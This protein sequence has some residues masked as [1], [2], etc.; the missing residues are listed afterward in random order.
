MARCS[1]EVVLKILE[2][3]KKKLDNTSVF[4]GFNRFMKRWLV[5][6]GNHAGEWLEKLERYEYLSP[7]ERKHLLAAIESS[8]RV[9]SQG[10]CALPPCTKAAPLL[11]QPVRYLKGVGPSIE[12]K[13]HRLDIVT[14]EDLLFFFPRAYRD[15]GEIKPIVKLEGRGIETV[16]GKVTQHRIERT[17]RGPLLKIGVSDGT[18]EVYLVCFNRGY[19]AQVLRKGIW[20]CVSGS[21]Q[22][23]FG[24][25]E[26]ATF[27]YEIGKPDPQVFERIVPVYSLTEGLTP[28]TLRRIILQA[29]DACLQ[30]VPEVLPVTLRRRLGLLSKREAIRELHVPVRSTLDELETRRS[31]AHRTLILEEF[32]LFALSLKIRKRTLE[33]LRVPPCPFKSPLVERFI[34]SLPFPLTEAQKRVCSEIAQDLASGRVMNRLVQGDVGS[35]KTL[36]AIISALRVVDAGRQ[37]AF[38]VPTEILAEQHYSR[39]REPLFAL[40]IRVGL[41]K[42]GNTKEKRLLLEA[43]RRKEVDIVIGT[44]ALIE[45]KVVFAD[46]G[47]VIVDEQHRFGVLQRAKLKEKATVPH[48]LVMTATPIP[49]TLAL[50]LYGDLDVSIV[51]EKPAGRKPTKTLCFPLEERFKAYSRVRKL[52]KEGRQAYVV[53]PAIEET[54][55]EIATVQEVFEELKR[56]WLSEFRIEIIHGKLPSKEKEEVMRRFS[57]G[58]IDVLVATS[59]IEVG[60]D[61]P[62]AS[63]MVVE[64]AERFGLAQLHQLRGRIGRGSEEGVCILLAALQGEEAR[65][66]MAVITATDDGFRIA[67]EDLRLRGPGEFYGV[68]Q[69]G[70][71]EFHVADPFSDW[72]LLEEAYREAERILAEDP[73]LEHPEYRPLRMEIERRFGRYLAFGEVG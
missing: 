18:G 64:N 34:Q 31:S 13:L 56:K 27:D 10:E 61:V 51:D 19:L 43:I 17:R 55:E 72:V 66:R 4:G 62:R 42:G 14:V 65:R 50:T 73:L 1:R 37:V 12:K 30:Q 7:G 44:H 47:L 24:T 57:H 8:L 39:F 33:K 22:R 11:C 2:Q 26:T 29:L 40:G 41:L 9:K 25:W 20:V 6:E 67:E 35:G 16:V 45:E 28:K 58:D 60:I 21:F 3:E 54:D 5:E 23:A 68:R 69:H 49:R 15:R 53:C 59:V 46:L 48:T 70:V 36:V 52:L 32:L 63:V 71:P 38:M